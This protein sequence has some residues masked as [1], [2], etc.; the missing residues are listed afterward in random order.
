MSERVL[1]V[2]DDP[3][4][5]K[6]LSTVL[7]R[8]GMS[9]VQAQDG[10]EG[11]ELL[12][13]ERPDLVLTDVMMP[14]MDGFELVRRVRSDPLIAATPL[15]IAS[16]KGE[17]EDKVKGLD[18]GANDYLSKPFSPRELV[19]RVRS[20]IRYQQVLR[21][22]RV[23]LP[24]GPFGAKGL[25]HL[26]T[27][28]FETFV[29]GTGNRSAY[30]ACLAAAESPGKRFNPLFLYGG[31]GVGKTHLMCALANAVFQRT[32]SARILYL[33]SEV[34]SSQLVEA[35]R[36]R[37]AS[38]L[39]D[40]YLQAD[41]LLV[42]DIQFLA[43]SPSMQT[44]AADILSRLYDK[45][46]QIVISSDR[47]PEELEALT[48]EI[49][50][51]FGLGLVVRIDFPDA[52][53]RTNILR[54]TARRH[55][56]PLGEDILDYLAA[57][58]E[59]DLRTLTGAAKR[60]V[61][62]ATLSEVVVT[63]ETVDEV[64]ASLTE[65]EAPEPARQPPP[66]RVPTEP[67]SQEP[68]PLAG[69]YPPHVAVVRRIVSP[70]EAA[71]ALA[72][73]HELT[74]VA[75][76]TSAAI[77]IDTVNALAG[78]PGA[79]GSIPEGVEWVYLTHVAHGQPT[80]ILLALPRWQEDSEVARIVARDTL[81]FLVVLDSLSP[82]VLEARELIARL[83]PGSRMAVVVL[84]PTL[85]DDSSPGK[86]D[87]LSRSMRRLFKVPAP[88]PVIMAAKVSTGAARRWVRAALATSTAP[89]DPMPPQG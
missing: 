24:E 42:D 33:T 70:H 29:P 11:L 52:T 66:P 22:Q 72:E 30:E 63:K 57:T 32:P 37:R 76:A 56:W 19:A 82:K 23:P 61:A 26:A 45:G 13:G 73:P 17:E 55:G 34:F 77:A 15:I 75:L 1:V 27:L 69:E 8:E 48:S 87:A 35:Y 36:E 78:V 20:P 51:A 84:V 79:G 64:V 9:V 43:V 71:L 40:E 6:L 50:T 89:T 80:C 18:L 60:L 62:L 81:V 68:D 14:G 39:R 5:L 58:L 59:A 46:A 54:A 31:P 41:V 53:L 49:S 86:A 28:T 67:P 12:H 47:R 88:I 3:T 7:T 2:D 38:Q 83:S 4:M 25:E 16:A 44:V 65:P 85:E 21:T 74:V 10:V